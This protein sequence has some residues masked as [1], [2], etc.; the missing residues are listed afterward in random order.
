[1][2]VL[3]SGTTAAGIRAWLACSSKTSTSA[4]FN[5]IN[6]RNALAYSSPGQALGY[7]PRQTPPRLQRQQSGVQEQSGAKS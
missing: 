6:T 2:V 4:S 5:P 7:P 3:D 1:M